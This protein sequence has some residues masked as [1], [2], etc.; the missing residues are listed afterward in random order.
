MSTRWN[1]CLFAVLFSAGITGAAEPE[2]VTIVAARAFVDLLCKGDFEG[3]AKSYDEAMKKSFPPMKLEAIW[4]QIVNDV[5]PFQKQLEA[6]FEKLG[7]FDVVTVVC[8][9]EKIKVDI[10]IVF[11]REGRVTGLSLRPAQPK[12]EFTPPPYAKSDAYTE[13]ALIV[14]EGGEWPLPATLT[15]PRGDGPF[16]GVVLVHG[17]GGQDR[18]ETIGGN[19]PFRD[20]AWGLASQGVAVLRYEKRTRHYG[21]KMVALKQRLTIQEE[22]VEDALLAIALLRQQKAIDGQRVFVVGH[23]LGGMVAP[24]LGALDPK[25]AGLALLAGTPRP[26]EDVIVDQN[27]YMM[28]LQAEITDKDK[29]ALEEA[30]KQ[31]A[32]VKDPKLGLD[33]PASEL[34]GMP[35]AYWLA[36]RSLDAGATAAKLSMPIL[37]LQGERDFQATMTDFAAWK[38]ALMDRPNV[39]FKSYPKLNHLFLAGEG[40]STIAEYDRPGHVPLEVIDDVAA[41]VKKPG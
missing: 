14:G 11:D 38:K 34:L 17:S 37:V 16:P 6:P 20:L 23:S 19:K 27:I 22:V 26:L 40:K 29:A 31:A 7:K 9:F 3:A 35:A 32:K 13:K 18:D 5:G 10:R 25:L 36:L 1:R 39:R 21:E 8:Q 15:L 24:R 41:W 12:F 30:K 4:K 2:K 28:S 33:T